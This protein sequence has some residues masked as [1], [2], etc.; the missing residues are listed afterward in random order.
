MHLYEDARHAGLFCQHEPEFRALNLLLHI[1]NPDVIRQTELLPLHILKNPSLQTA[2]HLCTDI[3]R[4]TLQAERT[5]S[6]AFPHFFTRFFKRIAHPATSFLMACLL[7]HHFA[8]I[9]KGALLTISN[10]FLPSSK[11]RPISIPDIREILFFDSDSE[12]EDFA[13]EICGLQVS[14][15]SGIRL[16]RKTEITPSMSNPAFFPYHNSHN[17]GDSTEGWSSNSRQVLSSCLRQT[18]RRGVERYYRRQRSYI[19][20]RS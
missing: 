7:E 1:N 13:V 4:P 18:R 17:P 20:S 11:T 2:I 9:R 3:Q 19:L 5:P 8:E 16:T 6:S 14:D 12:V 10:S 15:D